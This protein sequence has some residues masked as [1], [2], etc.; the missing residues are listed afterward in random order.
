MHGLGEV[1]VEAVDESDDESVSGVA[2]KVAMIKGVDD[3]D[4]WS[5]SSEWSGSEPATTD[6]DDDYDDDANNEERQLTAEEALRQAAEEGLELVRSAT[7]NTGYAGVFKTRPG[8]FR[9]Y[10]WR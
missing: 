1:E 9:A 6:D 3:K 10:V 4:G 7:S 5:D 2:M 8:R